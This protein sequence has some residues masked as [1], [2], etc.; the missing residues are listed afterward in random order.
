MNHDP[1][2]P[3]KKTI[4]RKKNKAEGI[5]RQ[6]REPSVNHDP[7]GPKKTTKRKSKKCESSRSIAQR[8]AYFDD[9]SPLPHHPER[10]AKMLTNV[11]YTPYR[12]KRIRGTISYQNGPRGASS[13]KQIRT[14]VPSKPC[15]T[16]PGNDTTQTERENHADHAVQNGTGE[17]HTVSKTETRPHKKRNPGTLPCTKHNRGATKKSKGDLLPAST[18]NPS[19]P[20]YRDVRVR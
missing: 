10:W 16:E 17:N 20:L 12:T 14:T 9:H 4:H 2:A 1:H 13:H 15:K 5:K 7:L 3:E 19:S 11:G 8:S 6:R 18:P